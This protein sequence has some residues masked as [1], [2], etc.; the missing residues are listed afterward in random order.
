MADKKGNN[1]IDMLKRLMNVLTIVVVIASI[2]T[3]DVA[4]SV[5]HYN[6][7]GKAEDE[8]LIYMLIYWGSL[9]TLNY[10]FFKKFTI[11]HDNK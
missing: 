9:L 6:L 7:R 2:Y 5:E 1:A 11:W 4:S 8:A 10:I 3:W